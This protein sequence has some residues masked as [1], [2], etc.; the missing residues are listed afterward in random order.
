MCVMERT[1]GPKMETQEQTPLMKGTEK[2]P[3]RLCADRIAREILGLE[4]LTVR[5]RDHLDFHDLGVCSIRHA[6]EAA[7]A[8]GRDSGK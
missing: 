2:T 6:L 5:N 4:T 7:Y 8:A 3:A 1:K